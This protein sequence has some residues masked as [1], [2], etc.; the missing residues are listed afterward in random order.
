[1]P[2]MVCVARVDKPV[3]LVVYVQSS[4]GRFNVVS[5]SAQAGAHL[6]RLLLVRSIA[7]GSCAWTNSSARPGLR[8][9]S[10]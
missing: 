6:D 10:T 3:E 4:E 5:N 2:I 8:S 7:S 1:M 9:I